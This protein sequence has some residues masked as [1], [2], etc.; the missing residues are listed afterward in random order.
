MSIYT[1]KMS[2]APNANALRSM[3]RYFPDWTEQNLVLPEASSHPGVSQDGTMSAGGDGQQYHEF[4]LSC[5]WVLR[6][7]GLREFFSELSKHSLVGNCPRQAASNEGSESGVTVLTAS[8][9]VGNDMGY[10][11]WLFPSQITLWRRV[12]AYDCSWGYSRP[13]SAAR[14]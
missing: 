7:D 2:V 8:I 3:K 9:E 11:A 6:P 12:H 5:N 1:D 10:H 13:H 14:D 4:L